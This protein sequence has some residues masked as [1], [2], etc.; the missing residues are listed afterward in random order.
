MKRNYPEEELRLTLAQNLVFLRKSRK[1][2]LSQ[3]ALARYL[4]LPT[5][6]VMNYENGKATPMAYAVLRLA[7]YYGC[8][9]EDL[10]PP[11]QRQKERSIH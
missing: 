3:K 7:N 5:K 8:T 6:T 9:V 1:N 2:R 11:N 10:L 4:Q